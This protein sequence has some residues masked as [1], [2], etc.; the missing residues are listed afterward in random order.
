LEDDDDEDD[1][2][3]GVVADEF[4]F[5][6]EEMDVDIDGELG[7]EEED[8]LTDGSVLSE[9]DLVSRPDFSREP[10]EFCF[11]FYECPCIN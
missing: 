9:E 4:E 6:V 11:C 1:F 3:D 8:W 5:D 7:N 2:F 10:G